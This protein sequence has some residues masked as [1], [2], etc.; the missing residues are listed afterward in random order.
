[1]QQAPPPH[2]MAA[3]T[4]GLA[5]RRTTE[6]LGP[7][8]A[9]VQGFVKRFLV[10]FENLDLD[11]FMA[12]FS[13]RATVFF[14]V[15]EPPGRYSGKAAVRAHFEK[16]FS[17]IRKASPASAPPFHRLQAEDL[18]IQFLGADA[19]IV[20]FHLRNQARIARRTLALT[21]SGGKWEIAHLHASNVPVDE[22]PAAAP[23]PASPHPD[24]P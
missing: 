24:H 13:D 8:Q 22:P 15:P 2:L 3:V 14:P 20:T 19:A 7:R 16:V 21:R 4:P 12:C 23:L 17:D 9:E 10:S 11:A 6:A 18:E 5:G 1:M